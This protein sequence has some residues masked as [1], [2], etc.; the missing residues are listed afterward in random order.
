MAFAEALSRWVQ[1]EFELAL[2]EEELAATSID[3]K[4]LRG[5]LT[6]H[7]KAV[8]LPRLWITNWVALSAAF[9]ANGRGGE[10]ART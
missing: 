4:T 5:T 3:G 9:K 8:H 1:D 6:V 7:Q 10:F 2:D